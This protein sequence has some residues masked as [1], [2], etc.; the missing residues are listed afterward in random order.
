MNQLTNHINGIESISNSIQ[1][2]FSHPTSSHLT[3]KELEKLSE[4]NETC[5][6]C[7]GK[8]AC[9]EL[10]SD[11]SKG[12]LEV[13]KTVQNIQEIGQS[14]Q[15]IYRSGKLRFWVKS[16]P[17]SPSLMQ[18]FEKYICTK[19]G[20]SLNHLT[21]CENNFSILPLMKS[22]SQFYHY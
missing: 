7:F 20:K 18:G 13:S 9:H 17:S 21:T 4:V 22:T 16:K 2:L 8:D 10:Q 15:G 12:V 19:T 11:V 3:W 5:P 6:I 14:V 1:Y